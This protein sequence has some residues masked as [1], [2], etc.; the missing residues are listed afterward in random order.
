MKV[1]LDGGTPMALP[2]GHCGTPAV[3]RAKQ[4]A[5]RAQQPLPV[6]VTVAPEVGVAL[7]LV[8]AA[9]HVFGA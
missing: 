8:L 4:R 3:S 5:Q 1:P 2:L 6:K 9:S 7:Q